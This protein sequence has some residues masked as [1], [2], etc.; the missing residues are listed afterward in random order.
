MAGD[1]GAMLIGVLL[2]E[3]FIHFNE[4]SAACVPVSNTVS[5]CG[6][7]TPTQCLYEP[8]VVCIFWRWPA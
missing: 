4:M 2:D 7:E 8:P 1:N 3:T 5:I 6:L